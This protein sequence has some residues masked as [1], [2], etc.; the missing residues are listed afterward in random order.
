MDL[1]AA[2]PFS[3]MQKLHGTTLPSAWSRKNVFQPCAGRPARRTMY[4]E[5]VD[6][7]T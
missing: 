2:T 1:C 7:E 6:C 4:R 5:T 3:V